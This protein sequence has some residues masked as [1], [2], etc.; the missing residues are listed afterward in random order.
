MNYSNLP[1]YS[2]SY[3]TNEHLMLEPTLKLALGWNA[4]KIYLQGV[5]SERLNDGYLDYDRFMISAGLALK[6]GAKKAASSRE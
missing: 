6:F 5:Y 2:R 1:E 3:A 4:V